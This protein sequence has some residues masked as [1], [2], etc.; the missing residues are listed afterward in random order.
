MAAGVVEDNDEAPI[1]C[2]ELRKR[3]ER[4]IHD[5]QTVE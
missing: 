3:G 5:G 2:G 1:L 4:S